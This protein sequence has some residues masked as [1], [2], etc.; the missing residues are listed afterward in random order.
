MQ[1]EAFVQLLQQY[2][3]VEKAMVY[4][5]DRAVHLQL[6]ELEPQL[7]NLP[8]C[9]DRES[10]EFYLTHIDPAILHFN[11][12]SYTDSLLQIVRATHVKVFIN[13]LWETE[14]AYVKNGNEE[15]LKNLLAKKPNV[16]QTDYPDKIVEYFN[17]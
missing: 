4:H 8:I 15:P 2:D 10:I 14:E 1:L 3:M 12:K 5:S 9:S 6:F 7:I 13:T 17:K 16:V 11:Y